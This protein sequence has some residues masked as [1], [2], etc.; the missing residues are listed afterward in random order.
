[1]TRSRE[2]KQP[3][4][5]LTVKQARFVAEYLIDFQGIA[6]GKR[7]GYSAH[8]VTHLLRNP[9][10]AFAL[11]E[12]QQK[13]ADACQISAERVLAEF[14]R[15]GFSDIR[16]VFGPKGEIVLPQDMPE[17]AARAIAGIDVA[18]R[19]VP[20][21]DG[22]G[23]EV[24]EVVK[25]KMHDKIGALNALAKHTGVLK[26][27]PA[28]PGSVAWSLDPE[29]LAKMTDDQV[30]EAVRLAKLLTEGA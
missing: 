9:A 29:K 18:K 19:R 27:P 13:H 20:A 30:R 4:R 8:S 16:Q 11:A 1:M 15:I 3:P 6:A 24:E 5:R 10:V 22:D 25:F 2:R 7:A 28:A 21:K 26:E 17:N 14:A 23:F 12:A